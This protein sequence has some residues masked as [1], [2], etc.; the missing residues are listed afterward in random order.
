MTGT[1]YPLIDA[2]DVAGLVALTWPA[3]RD[4]LPAELATAPARESTEVLA[5]TVRHLG[6]QGR[7]DRALFD[8][9]PTLSRAERAAVRSWLAHTATAIVRAS[10]RHNEAGSR[11]LLARACESAAAVADEP[12]L[13]ATE[14]VGKLPLLP[15][16][17]DIGAHCDQGRLVVDVATAAEMSVADERRCLG[18]YSY[19]H[20]V[21]LIDRDQGPASL[22]ATFSHE[23][24]HAL[25]PARGEPL[26][27]VERERFAE[28]LCPRLLAH[29]PTTVAGA[30]PHIAAALADRQRDRDPEQFPAA[31][32]ESALIFG[33][34]AATL[35]SAPQETHR[36]ELT[37][38]APDLE[39]AGV[40]A[41]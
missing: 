3:S 6:E 21:V 24:A 8:V 16:A 28:A 26:D 9:A 7:L 19:A 41:A 36:D 5:G 13:V 40:G 17:R 18:L 37:E 1:G 38:P 30:R 29:E 2:V 4:R 10:D 11:I 25:D 39:P 12:L 31:G 34:C 20:G 35:R 22:A 15:L 27:R 33:A 14:L 23:L 32:F